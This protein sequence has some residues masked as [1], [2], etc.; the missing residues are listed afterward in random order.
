MHLTRRRRVR[1]GFTLVELLV[2]IF[3]IG[4]LIALLLPA[5]QAARES[6]RKAQCS[7]NLKQLGLGFLNFESDNRGLPARR[8]NTATQGEAGWGVFLLPYIEQ[9]PLA[10]AYQW[11]YDC[12]DPNNQAVTQTQIAT[13]VCPSTTRTQGQYI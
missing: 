3:I 1:K 5:V 8:F 4:I 13:F 7:N 12:F 10:F 2:V 6:A 9:E 11:Q